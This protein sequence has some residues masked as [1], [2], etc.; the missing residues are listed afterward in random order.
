MTRAEIIAELRRSARE[1]VDPYGEMFYLTWRHAI[2][3][4]SGKDEVNGDFVSEQFRLYC[5]FVA[6]A[7]EDEC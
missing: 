6:C 1:D 2:A 3:W 4:L 5:I 7:L